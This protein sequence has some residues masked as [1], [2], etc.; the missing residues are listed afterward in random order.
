MC[1]CGYLFHHPGW[2]V[3]IIKGQCGLTQRLTDKLTLQCGFEV[4]PSTALYNASQWLMFYLLNCEL[5]IETHEKM[6][7]YKSGLK[8]AYSGTNSAK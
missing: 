8:E 7:I 6:L 3:L 5:E 4:M 1:A 2:S